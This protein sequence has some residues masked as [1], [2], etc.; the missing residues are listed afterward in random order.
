[1]SGVTNNRAVASTIIIE[2]RRNGVDN[3]RD[4]DTPICAILS[5]QPSR[6]K[7]RNEGRKKR[8]KERERLIDVRRMGPRVA[9]MGKKRALSK[10]S[11]RDL[12]HQGTTVVFVSS[13]IRRSRVFSLFFFVGQPGTR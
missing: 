8:K 10:R 13:G 6:K 1:M 7:E 2:S 12:D 3:D 11:I 4:T 9:R 5:H